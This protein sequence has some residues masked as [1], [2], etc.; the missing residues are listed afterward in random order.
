MSRNVTFDKFDMLS[1]WK[2]KLMRKK[3]TLGE[4]KGGIQK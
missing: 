3:K 4:K 1:P 2:D